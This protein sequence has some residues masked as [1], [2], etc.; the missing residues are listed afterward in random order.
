[1]RRL[2]AARQ[3]AVDDGHAPHRAPQSH[4]CRKARISSANDDSIIVLIVSHT[5]YLLEM[6]SGR[7]ASYFCIDVRANRK[8]GRSFVEACGFGFLSKQWCEARMLNH[9]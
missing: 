8:V 6:P 4:G 3:L 5:C 1:M 7:T 9:C 2:P